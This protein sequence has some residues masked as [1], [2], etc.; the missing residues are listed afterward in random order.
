MLRTERLPEGA[1]IFTDEW[2]IRLLLKDT[3]IDPRRL[4][5]ND[6]PSAVA[7]VIEQEDTEPVEMVFATAEN[8]KD[9]KALWLW[10]PE[11]ED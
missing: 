9:P 11:A 8:P 3:A 7:V 2:A 1:K 5:S 10:V 6:L 4:D